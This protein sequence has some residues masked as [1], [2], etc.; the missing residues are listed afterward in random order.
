[1]KLNTKR[2][3]EL[4]KKW[5]TSSSLQWNKFW[6]IICGRPLWM[7]PSRI[8]LS[9]YTYSSHEQHRAQTISTQQQWEHWS[10]VEIQWTAKYE[11]LTI[12]Q[13]RILSLSATCQ[14]HIQQPATRFMTYVTCMLGD[15]DI[16]SS[17]NAHME[18]GT[19]VTFLRSRP[20][21]D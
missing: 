13:T 8:K 1:V 2:G 16:C 11:H 18:H 3:L 20:G 14:W 5:I 6:L 12:K 17:H 10:Q 15:R 19:T 4:W 7:T 9:T 21:T